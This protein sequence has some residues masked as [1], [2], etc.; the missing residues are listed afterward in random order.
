MGKKKPVASRETTGSFRSTGAPHKVC[1][2][3]Q[4]LTIPLSRQK[5]QRVV[6]RIFPNSI[7]YIRRPGEPR[8]GPL[9]SPGDHSSDA[10]ISAELDHLVRY[11]YA[12]HL[13]PGG[14]KLLIYRTG[15]TVA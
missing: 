3:G 1:T 9:S 4:A 13:T 2:Q 12:D 15:L 7:N 11:V 6:R 5:K 14:H 8:R 10:L